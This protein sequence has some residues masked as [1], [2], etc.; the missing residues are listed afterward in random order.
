M[1]IAEA[2]VSLVR[3]KELEDQLKL[4][5]EQKSEL[6]DPQVKKLEAQLRFVQEEKERLEHKLQHK[7]K[8]CQ[9]VHKEDVCKK[10]N[11]GKEN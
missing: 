1:L 6:H 10:Y 4:E 7:E 5:Q 2:K 8:H 3:V 9:K 11:E